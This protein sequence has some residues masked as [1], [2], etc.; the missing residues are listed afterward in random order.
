MRQEVFLQ[1][2]S[3]ITFDLPVY[4]EFQVIIDKIAKELQNKDIK[5]YYNK[6]SRPD[7]YE[8][9]NYKLFT[10]KDGHYSWR[11][12]QII[13]P[14]LYVSLV[15]IITE[16]NNWKFIKD[17]FQEF[18]D[19][20]ISDLNIVCSS[21]PVVDNQN[22][23]FNKAKQ[24]I[25]WHDKV[26]QE[27]IRLGLQY[28]YIFH[29]D[30]SDCYGA[31]YTHAISWAL[32]GRE[33]AKI[34]KNNTTLL[35]NKIDACLRSM[36]YGQ[37]NGIPQGSVLMDFI[38]EILLGY[39]DS[40]LLIELEKLK[41]KNFKIIRYRDDYRIFVNVVEDGRI[42][43]KSLSQILA[44]LG[45]RLNSTK[46]S[47]YQDVISAS[48]KPD[49]LYWLQQNKYFKSI[50]SEALVLLKFAQK[51]PN[52]GTM[53]KLLNKFDNKV[54]IAKYIEAEV[55]ISIIVNIICISPQSFNIC[56]S[57]ISKLLNR[58]TIIEKRQQI[59]TSI[60]IKLNCLQ[61]PEIVNLWLQRIMIFDQDLL[62]EFKYDTTE[63]VGQLCN[64]VVSFYQKTNK[65]D[66]KIIWNSQWLN[67]N[68][69]L[70]K[71]VDDISIISHKNLN[72]VIDNDEVNLFS[73]YSIINNL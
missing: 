46:T 6:S 60:K 22:N 26:E 10:N 64:Y 7:D 16:Q 43:I 15:N 48:I 40:I 5:S 13:H 35:G 47:Y 4:F 29:T 54:K 68:S 36:S 73:N 2:K 28:Q 69:G 37:T 59:L 31:I 61:N 42:I 30:I 63:F 65:T 27:S 24:I 66:K 39:V 52:S 72:S 70:K 55:L 25:T 57:I 12:L 56:I 53:M 50:Q 33:N 8:D 51:F 3:Y 21:I 23:I 1:S 19:N 41:V 44:D 58:I 34:N 45:M 71:I 14:V 67:P 9:V 11:M 49:K 18:Y 38:A 17:Q 62:E 20:D 32:H